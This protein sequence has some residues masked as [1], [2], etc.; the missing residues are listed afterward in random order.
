MRAFIEASIEGWRS[1]MADPAPGD[2]LIR[3]ANPDIT[4]DVLDNSVAVMRQYGIVDS[5]DSLTLGIGAMTDAR[6]KGFFDTMVQAG[7]L[8][9]PTSITTRPTRC[10][11]WMPEIR[12][13]GQALTGEPLLRLRGVRKAFASGT[14]ALDGM[15]LDIRRGEFVSL[16]G[17]SGCG[18]STA[19]RLMAGLGAT[20]RRHGAPGSAPRRHRLR[21]PGA[22][23]DA[24]AHG[25]RQ[26]APAAADWPGMG[27][28]RRPPRSSRT[29]SPASD[30]PDS[31]APIRASCRAA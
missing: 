1:Y 4:Q 16:L 26:C 12:H 19:L 9:S 23:A 22:D 30:S 5:G 14:V 25:G 24:V 20:Q 10:S 2:A 7:P 18:K 29:R 11:S 3:K 21:V 15:E 28:R 13:G 8:Q 17:P 31:S 6:W 27:R